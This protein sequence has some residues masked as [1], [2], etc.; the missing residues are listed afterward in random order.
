M[1]DAASFEKINYSIRPAK[2]TQRRMIIEAIGRLASF[3]P[4]QDYQY[5]GFGSTFFI[6]FKLIHREYGLTD[7]T[8]VE[9]EREKRNRFDFNKPYSCVRMFYGSAAEFLGSHK[10]RW[11]TPSIIWL[12]YD[13]RLGDSVL[14][15]IHRVI[16][17]APSGSLLL[18]TV[19]AEPPDLDERAEILGEDIDLDWLLEWVEGEKL[20]RLGGW[21]LASAYHGLASASVESRLRK[22]PGDRLWR[23]I[24]HFHYADGHRMLTFGGVIV[25]PA[26]LGSFDRCNFDDLEFFQSG[27]EPFLIEV[28][29]LTGPEIH[30]LAQGMPKLN[31]RT[32]DS[33]QRLSISEEDVDNYRRLYRYYPQFVESHA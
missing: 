8:S 6:D 24:V 23:Q 9:I 27:A 32:R 10:M 26:D 29:N 13:Y 2:A 12:D 4:L 20:F 3:G 25:D 22:G 18:V 31:K 19:D 16:D 33:M 1:S 7:L 11:S 14:A 30:R 15:D 21:G 17:K 28:P 5:I